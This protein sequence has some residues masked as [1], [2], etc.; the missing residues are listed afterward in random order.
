MIIHLDKFSQ[1]QIAQKV[2][3]ECFW[4]DYR[5]TVA[6]IL[7]KIADREAGFSEFI[8]SKILDNGL[9]PSFYLKKIFS[10]IIV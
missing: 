2:L 3:A 4:G 10:Q 8:F 7:E 6:E 5:L 9:Y 1:T